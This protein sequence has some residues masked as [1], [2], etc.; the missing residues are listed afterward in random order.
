[1]ARCTCAGVPGDRA[2]RVTCS[3]PVAHPLASFY[4]VTIKRDARASLV[5]RAGTALVTRPPLLEA[6][7]RSTVDVL[8]CERCGGRL[9][10]V[11]IATKRDDI[12]RALGD[13]GY[14]RAPPSAPP[15][16][17]SSALVHGQLRLAFG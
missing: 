5:E 3:P 17:E 14:A 2:G 1:M 8:N 11:E 13:L 6:V 10:L 9:R 15:R 4:A 16:A 12:S 7:V